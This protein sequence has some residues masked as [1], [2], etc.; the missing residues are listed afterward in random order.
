MQGRFFML[1]RLGLL[2]LAVSGCGAIQVK[3]ALSIPRALIKPIDM[4]VGVYYSPE[5]RKFEHRETRWGS[6]WKIAL[7]EEHVRMTDNLFA[8]A[9][10]KTTRLDK[11]PTEGA[12]APVKAIIEPRI[13]QYSFI[14]P[15]DTGGEFYAVTIKYRLNLDTPSGAPIDSYQF[16][17]YGTAE[18]GGMSAEKPMM[19][20]TVVAM[21]DAAAKFLVQFSEQPAVKR[22]ALGEAVL[23][24]EIGQGTSE[25]EE[26]PMVD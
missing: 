25:S 3:P 11:F 15:R 10:T 26:V 20:A 8:Q 21:R 13:E 24:A 9:F 6:D 2:C 16:T 23:V 4:E 5:Y 1:L 22:L 19:A 7:G 12:S 17:G 18:S 14:T